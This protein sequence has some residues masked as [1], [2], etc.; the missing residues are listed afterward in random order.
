MNNL[1]MAVNIAVMIVAATIWMAWPTIVG[2]QQ[3]NLNRYG[4]QQLDQKQNRYGSQSWLNGVGRTGGGWPASSYGNNILRHYPMPVNHRYSSMV[5]GARQN[6]LSDDFYDTDTDAVS[7]YNP[8]P[9]DRMDYAVV[10][11]PSY[12]NVAGYYVPSVTADL[13][14][15]YDRQDDD[16]SY[17]DSLQSYYPMSG[18]NRYVPPPLPPPPPPPQNRYEPARYPTDKIHKFRKVF[19]SNLV[20]PSNA[21]KSPKEQQLYD[22]W[23]SLV[24]G[25]LD[26]I[27]QVSD[28]VDPEQQRRRDRLDYGQDVANEKLFQHLPQVFQQLQQKQ[29]QQQQQRQQ[30][31]DERPPSSPLSSPA[32]SSSSSSSSSFVSLPR[33]N[34]FNQ[35]TKGAPLIKRSSSP[36]ATVS[37]TMP[38]PSDDSD[39][40]QQLERLLRTGYAADNC[41]TAVMVTNTATT[42]TTKVADWTADDVA[43]TTVAVPMADGGQRE[44]VLPRPAG[45]KSSFESLLEAFAE[46]GFLGNYDKVTSN[47]YSKVSTQHLH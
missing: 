23:E 41:T 12:G 25:D 31:T 37:P 32:L 34:Q 27:Q 4:L 22:F 26:G 42:T 8:R 5:T 2:A 43:A 14:L 28:D 20:S 33:S 24:K 13:P 1:P 18:I 30:S 7:A 39:D 47:E 46:G 44:I 3:H 6:A 45:E 10:R 29:R 35:W 11:Y 36:T 21:F 38:T 15:V 16:L 40:V 17:D 19:L 9:Y